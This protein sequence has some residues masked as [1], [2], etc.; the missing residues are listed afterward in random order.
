M[1]A[2]PQTEALSEFSTHCG[3]F[4]LT[5]FFLDVFFGGAARLGVFTPLATHD[6]SDSCRPG[7]PQACALKPGLS[8]GHRQERFMTGNT[9][10]SYR[11]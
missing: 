3:L 10:M 7:S 4:L 6:M 1:Y 2:V 11:G 8:H 5:G 9:E